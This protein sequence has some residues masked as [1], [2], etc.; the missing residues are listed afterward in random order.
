[1]SADPKQ[2]PSALATVSTGSDATTPSMRNP[3]PVWIIILL[4]VLIFLSCVY[5]DTQ[6]GWEPIVYR[7]YHSVREV[8]LY[9]PPP[10]DGPNLAAGRAL[11]EQQCGICHDNSGAGKPGQAPPLVGSEWVLGSPNRLIRI[12]QLGLTGPIK[13]NGQDYS[14]ANSMPPI[15]APWSDEDLVNVL[16]DIRQAWGNKSVKTDPITVQHVQAVRNEVKGQPSTTSDALSKVPAAI[17]K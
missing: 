13:V 2:P 5:F 10:P 7:P 14:F 11:F 6:G 12:P 16:G 8:E 1:M 15:A 3:M 4:F 9:Q 17:K